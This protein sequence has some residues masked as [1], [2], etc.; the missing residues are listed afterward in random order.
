MLLLRR[1]TLHLPDGAGE[2]LGARLLQTRR[3]RSFTLVQHFRSFELSVARHRQFITHR[4]KFTHSKNTIAPNRLISANVKDQPH[5]C[6][7]QAVRKH[8]M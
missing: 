8:G 2:R 6:L 7:A 4:S 3:R 1:A 5:V